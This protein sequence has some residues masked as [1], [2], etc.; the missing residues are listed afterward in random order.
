VA[1]RLLLQ[2]V[3]V[4]LAERLWPSVTIYN[5]LEG[6]PRSVDLE[7]SLR[8]EVRDP[9]WALTR[10]WQVG[11]L[12]ADDAGSPFLSR[13]VLS[14]RR[15]TRYRPFDGIA[16]PLP[17]DLPLEAL[18]ERRPV[19]LTQGGRVAGLSIRLLMG[20]QWLR[21]I[22]GVGA[23]AD[24]FIDRYGVV[25][26][27]PTTIAD[28]DQ[29]AH[30]EAWHV[31]A[32]LGGRAMDGGAMVEY[33][34]EDAGHHVY[35]GVAGIANADKPALDLRAGDFQAWFARLFT[36]PDGT[37]DSAWDPQHLDYRFAVAATDTTGERI[38]SSEGYTGGRLDW[39]ALDTDRG[40]ATLVDPADVSQPPDDILHAPVPTEVR[41]EGMPN[42]R[43]RK[44]VV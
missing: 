8:T 9:L 26:P 6:R 20:R 30:L 24:A 42:H 1:E 18:V 33:L 5:R 25:A 16:Q 35:D 40:A 36:Q 21:M 15:L 39:W 28:A 23:Y 37:A 38:Y 12:E 27:D 7:R 11:E 29:A 44:S 13:I 17:D 34:A 22:A 43:D 31:F 19:V 32:A 41:F 2:D 14:H 10:Q 4:A 3:H